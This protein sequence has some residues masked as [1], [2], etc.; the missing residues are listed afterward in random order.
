MQGTLFFNV[1]SIIEVKRPPVI[2]LENVKNLKSHDQGRTFQVIR[3]TLEDELNYK[4]FHKV[5]DAARITSRN[6]AKESI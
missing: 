1:A 4:V 5:I 2:L 6:I 3:E